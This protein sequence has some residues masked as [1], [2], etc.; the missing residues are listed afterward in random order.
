MIQSNAGL[1]IAANTK[2]SFPINAQ[3]SEA[4]ALLYQKMVKQNGGTI[5]SIHWWMF[6][7]RPEGAYEYASFDLKPVG[8]KSSVLNICIAGR[9]EIPEFA[10]DGSEIEVK[11]AVDGFYLCVYLLGK[12]VAEFG[13]NRFE[14][15][16]GGLIFSSGSI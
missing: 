8:G 3:A 15:A 9:T 12:A 7:P 13:L 14:V 5:T 2:Q 11:D 10:E 16:D 4:L 6:R 1:F